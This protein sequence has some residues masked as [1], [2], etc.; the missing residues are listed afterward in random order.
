VRPIV[1]RG[2]FIRPDPFD[3]IEC[4]RNELVAMIGMSLRTVHLD[5][6]GDV[7]QDHA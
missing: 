2:R 6:W 3:R 7:Q 1:I 5:D 4:S